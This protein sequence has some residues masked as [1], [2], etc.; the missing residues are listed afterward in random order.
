MPQSPQ[1]IPV[2]N[3]EH[4]KRTWMRNAGSKCEKS[5]ESLDTFR[6]SPYVIAATLGCVSTRFF[7]KGS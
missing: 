6:P 5:R 3:T 4:K 2:G 7:M 1:G